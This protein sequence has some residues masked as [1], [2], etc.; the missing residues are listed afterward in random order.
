MK[1]LDILVYY[2]HTNIQRSITNQIR[3]IALTKYQKTVF[4]LCCIYLIFKKTFLKGYIIT[5]SILL[6]G[7]GCTNLFQNFKFNL[8]GHFQGQIDFFLIFDL[9]ILSLT[10]KMTLIIISSEMKIFTTTQTILS[11]Q[12]NKY[13]FYRV[14]IKCISFQNGGHFGFL[15]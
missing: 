11:D 12:K 15:I 4:S 7:K 6:H 9:E 10:L 2:S 13:I 5:Q 14:R 1:K 3:V 8:Q